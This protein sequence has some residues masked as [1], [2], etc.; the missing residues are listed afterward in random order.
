MSYVSY[1]PDKK[2]VE[3]VEKVLS[4]GINKKKTAEK[5]FYKNVIDPFGALFEI[6]AFDVDINTWKESELIRQCQKTLQNH[7]GS[8]HQEILGSINGWQDLGSGGVVDIKNDERKIIAE[9]KNKHNTV[10]G[11]DLNSKYDTLEKLVMPKSSE[12]KG[13]TS[14]FVQIIPKKPGAYDEYFTPSIRDT[15]GKCAANELIR[16]IDGASFYDLVTE[17]KN[18]LHELYVAL[19]SVIEDVLNEKYKKN[20]KIEDRASFNTLFTKA[21]ISK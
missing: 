4:I 8:F 6:A 3:A 11:G 17:K 9:V 21:Y 7:I 5:D 12:Y 18:S 14:Y 2:L 13:Y 16:V 1:L 10:S 15:G 20:F 19:P